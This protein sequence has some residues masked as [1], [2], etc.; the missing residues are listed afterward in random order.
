L[1]GALA[2]YQQTGGVDAANG[3]I[4]RYDYITLSSAPIIEIGPS[5]GPYAGDSKA[6]RVAV[7]S[8]KALPFS[9]LFLRTPPTITAEATAAA[10]DYGNY[11]V[12][13]LEKTAAT[14]ITFQGSAS[15]DLGCGV[16]TNSQ[17][18][19]AVSAGGASSIHASPVAAV[20]GIP[21]S[22]SYASGTELRPYTSAQADPYAALPLPNPPSGCNKQLS[23]APTKT[24]FVDNPTGVA[25]Y[26]NID[27]KG[28]VTFSP[29]V[30]YI[31]GGQFSAGSQSVISGDGVTFILT[32]STAA[33]NPSSVATMDINGGATID[34]T[35]PGTGTY[36]GI[37]FYQ[38]R[39][40]SAGT[41]NTMNGNSNSSL[42][43]ALYFPSQQL[44]FN[45][46]SG[47]ST[48]CLQLVARNIT[49]VGN[50][51]ISNVCPSDSGTP[52]ITGVHIRLV[53]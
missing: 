34:L 41:T 35:A 18:S 11:C 53:H 27:I 52:K 22:G 3:E 45:G 31:D 28:D 30:Y 51:S 42:Q 48:N 7:Q 43:G 47:M 5:K 6:V 49:F 14:G 25:C 23:V 19:S 33:V 39:R 40:A 1:A 50:T 38:D 29:G 26:S 37:L 21:G 9:S 8:S 44:L 17:G 16:V 2:N 36:A 20:G 46:T 15:I 13:S 24:A 32:S 10:V 4:A 12:V